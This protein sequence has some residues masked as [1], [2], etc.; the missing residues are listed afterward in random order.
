MCLHVLSVLVNQASDAQVYG[1]P[2]QILHCT[3]RPKLLQRLHLMWFAGL[4]RL[5]HKLGSASQTTWCHGGTSC[6][7]QHSHSNPE[8]MCRPPH[9]T[10]D[11]QTSCP[12]S[13]AQTFCC[14]QLAGSRQELLARQH[15]WF[16]AA[17]QLNS[18][19]KL[20]R[21]MQQYCKGDNRTCDVLR[22][23]K[24]TISL[25]AEL[26]PLQLQHIMSLIFAIGQLACCASLVCL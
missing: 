24:T 20:L 15:C 26:L 21:R 13:S 12:L 11:H 19:G 5:I 7:R 1:G 4:C 2:K 22:L 9:S 14:Y 17:S 18:F 8:T 23:S 6:S 3:P 25:T 16:A 10:T